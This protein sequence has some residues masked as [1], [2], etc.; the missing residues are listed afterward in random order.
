MENT[1]TYSPLDRVIWDTQA[2]DAI[3]NEVKRLNV[4]KVYIVA[5]STLSKKTDEI[6]KIK[7][8]LGNKFV[9]LFDSCIQHSPLENVI[10]CVKS[11]QEKNPDIIITVGGGTPIDTVKV[12]QL[13]HSLEINTVADLKKISNKH[14]NK[15]SKIRQIAVPTT[16]S[17]GEYSI[18][19][20]AMDTKTQLKERYTGNDICPQVV[21][22]D[23]S[24]TL[25]TPDWLWL[26][27]A[28]R[29]V[30]H[31]VEGLCSSSTNPLMPPMALN[32][33]QLFAR[34]LR[35]TF[36]DREDIFSRSLSQKA[37]WMIAKNL[38]NTSMGASHGIG[39][40]LGSIGSVPHGYTSCVM[41]PAVLK[42][43]ESFN[44]EKQKWISNAL[45][46]PKLSAAEAVGE[47]VSDLGLPTTLGEVGIKDD[48]WDKIADYGLKHP[49][50]LSNPR[51]IT[52]KDDIIEILKLAS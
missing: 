22:L 44:K 24:L 18:I 19:G 52:K 7:N 25:H 28:I 20:G 31:A 26:S 17:G 12:V 21:I 39:Y 13:C 16:L 23:P 4:N 41:L 42:W 9:G 11:V 50:V 47:L 48:Q 14:Q 34:S 15:A 36:K 40:L 46:R 5:S 8:I 38:G 37:V 29:S 35:E 49:T 1:Y 43:N 51:P 32:S 3:L 6:S 2:T 27:T 33:L 30:D 45:G 10:D